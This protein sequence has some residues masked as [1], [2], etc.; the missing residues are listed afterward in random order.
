MMSWEYITGFFD[1]EGCVSRLHENDPH[2]NAHNRIFW[3]ILITQK[4]RNVLDIIQKFIGYGKVYRVKKPPEICY[5]YTIVKQHEVVDFLKKVSPYV[6]VKRKKL[7]T[8][9]EYPWQKI[10]NVG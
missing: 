3:R 2:S 9:L 8:T 1:G 7:Q 4:H 6:I 10:R 5:C